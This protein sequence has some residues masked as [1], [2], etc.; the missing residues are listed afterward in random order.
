MNIEIRDAALEARIKKQPR[1]N[2]SARVEE[3][4][5]RLLEIQKDQDRWLSAN[6][7]TINVKVRR[8]TGPR[9]RNPRRTP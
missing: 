2:G 7:E 1:A 5:L 6:R 4:S 3:V 8:G 9:P